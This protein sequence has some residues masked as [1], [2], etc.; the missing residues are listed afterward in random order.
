MYANC[1]VEI[2]LN[3]YREEREREKKFFS[4]FYIKEQSTVLYRAMCN[5]FRR[6]DMTMH[7]S[8]K[9]KYAFTKKIVDDAIEECFFFNF[10]FFLN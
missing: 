1:N 2:W 5:L 9:Q 8:E 6:N 3:E 7:S 10:F 4:N